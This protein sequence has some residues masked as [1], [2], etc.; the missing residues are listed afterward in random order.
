MKKLI[1][2]IAFILICVTNIRAQVSFSCY[3]REYCKWNEYSKEFE[4]CKGF[5]ESSLFVMNKGET[6]FTHTIETMKSTYYVN[7]REYNNEKEVWTYYV[8]S[9]VGNKYYYVFDPKNKEVRALV[10]KDGETM[11]IRFFVKAVF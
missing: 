2:V 10:S 3:Y 9:D 11:L 5:E 8:T 6:M 4:D 1:I 7:E